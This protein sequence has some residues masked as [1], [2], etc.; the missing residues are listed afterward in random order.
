MKYTPKRFSENEKTEA[1]S[2][3]VSYLRNSSGSFLDAES[4]N[5]NACRASDG[6]GGQNLGMV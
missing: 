1:A 3:P 5:R 4:N 6:S 2:L